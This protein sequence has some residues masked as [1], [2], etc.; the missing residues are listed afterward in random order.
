VTVPTPMTVKEQDLEIRRHWKML[1]TVVLDSRREYVV[2]RGEVQPRINRYTVEIEYSPTM[3]VRGPRVRVISPELTR[4]PDNPE[5]SLPHVYDRNGNPWLCLFDPR[6][7][8]W[9]GWMPIADKI[10]PWMLD[11]LVCYENWLMTGV[12]HGGGRHVTAAVGMRFNLEGA[13]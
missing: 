2:W 10:V 6:G 1:R 3:A 5:G 7:R 13:R 4:L 8:E 12:W 9:T 11:W